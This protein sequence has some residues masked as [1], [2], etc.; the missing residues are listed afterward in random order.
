MFLHD[1]N[2]QI[3]FCRLNAELSYT[4]YGY[5]A[6]R[7]KWVASLRREKFPNLDETTEEDIAVHNVE[8]SDKGEE[9]DVKTS[10]NDKDGGNE[11]NVDSDHKTVDKCMDSMNEDKSNSIEGE[12]YPAPEDI[13]EEQLLRAYGLHRLPLFFPCV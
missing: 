7:W 8:E 9:I 6:E 1:I 12:A 3:S 4:R 5:R 10:P 11:E 2:I 13:V